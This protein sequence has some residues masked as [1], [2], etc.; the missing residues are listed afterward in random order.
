MATVQPAA[1]SAANKFYFAAWRWHFYAGLFVIPF[2][3]ILALTGAFMMI[4]ADV[5]N[6]LGYAPDVAV[7]DKALPV[8]TQARAAAQAV[9]G[10][11]FTTYIAPEAA[12]RPAYFEFSK[13]DAYVA[14]AVDP[15]T[16]TVLNAQDEAST[17]YALAERIH[18]TLLLGDAGDR[19]IEAAA[20]LAI[21]LIATG[22][23]MWWPRERGVLSSLFPRLSAKGRAFWKELHMTAGVWIS[24]VL[25]LF[26]LS[27]LA[28]AGIWGGKFVQPWSSF[29]AEKWD[30][31]PLSDANHASLNHD[32]LHE[33]PWG[34]E[35]TPLPASGST[36]GTPAV[37]QPVVLDSVVQ[38]AAANG[39]HGQFKVGIPGGETG[40]YTVSFDG[41]NED[42]V[43]P[44]N[45]R[46]VHIDRYTGNVL[47]D[48]GYADYKPLGKVMAWGIGLHKG[49]AGT[50]NFVFNLAFIA[51]LLLVCTSGV[52]MWWRRR[53]S[54]AG[55][56]VA[57]PLPSELPLW[58]GAVLVALATS[59]AFPMAGIT[60][61]VVLAID[62]LLVSNVPVLKRALS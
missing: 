47:A 29:P 40:V 57:P 17:Y 13:D 5:G 35:L 31:V 1:P 11:T 46:F 38:W 21:V 61:L 39:F 4:Y 51:L 10:G 9:P 16:A 8:S 28:W 41:R 43:T 25:V 24:L 14:V 18:G 60:L 22:L 56:L 30:N 45:D 52:V 49:L 33:V 23:Y 48:I 58:K 42:G 50:W 44:S 53:P 32:V 27:G 36:A 12:D 54:G 15:Y 19:I 26:L 2:L 59:L 55:R 7:G 34:L 62:L 20:S 3:V 37:P 6:S